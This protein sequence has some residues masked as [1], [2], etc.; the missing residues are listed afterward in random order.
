MTP[1]SALKITL[2][3][4]TSRSEKGRR[5]AYRRL[6][7]LRDEEEDPAIRE[8]LS[9]KVDEIGEFL[10]MR[11]SA[12]IPSADTGYSTINF[13]GRRKLIRSVQGGAPGLGRK[14]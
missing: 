12:R 8:A 5:R 1:E 9:R 13:H 14:R 10:Q 7:A 4:L 6:V 11:Q 2:A 3:D